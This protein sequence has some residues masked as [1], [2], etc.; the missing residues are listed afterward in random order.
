MQPDSKP[1]PSTAASPAGSARAL[2]GRGSPEAAE[3]GYVFDNANVNAVKQHRCLARMLDEP[4]TRH[5][6][7]TGVGA[8]WDCLEVGAGGGSVARWL[9]A[10]VGPT[11]S[12]LATD[13]DPQH[14]AR[15]P[16]LTIARHDIVCDPLPEMAFDLIHARLVLLHLPERELVLDRLLRALRPSGWLQ[17]DEFDIS[18][19]PGLLMPDD[20]AATL[21][22]AFLA[23]KA[24]MFDRAGADGA[25][26]QHAAQ[27]MRAAGFIDVEPT[28]ELQVWRAGSG[29]SELLAHHTRHLRDQFLAQGMTDEQL[30]GVRTLLR[31]PTF[32][33]TSCPIYFVHGRRADR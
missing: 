31:D 10:R 8:G 5:L 30:A 3:L 17:L 29:G 20:D 18:Y 25:W 28:V 15:A 21:F 33:A 14:I 32:R 22:D 13:I 16:G 26:G 19:G 12:V 27:A 23:C 6:L 11:G 24:R 2:P 1:R 4:T 9:A 7:R